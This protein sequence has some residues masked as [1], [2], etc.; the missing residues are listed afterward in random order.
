MTKADVSKFEAALKAR[1]AELKRS[2]F[3][4]QSLAIT[5][6]ADPFDARLLAA[7]RESA[8]QLRA[9]A[10]RLLAQVH[11]AINRLREGRFGVCLRCEES[12]APR[13]LE[14]VPWT[15]YC[16]SCQARAEQGHALGMAA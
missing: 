5:K 6:P 12:I 8:A 4:R 14:A 1:A 2:I 3:E 13:R 10:S 7:E 15:S 16:I 11:A 9:R